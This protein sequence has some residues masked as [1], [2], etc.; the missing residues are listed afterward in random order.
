MKAICQMNYKKEEAISFFSNGHFLGCPANFDD[1][2]IDRRLNL[3]RKF[4]DFLNK[5]YNLVEIGCGN[6]AS[7]FKI[8]KEIKTALGLDI[9]NE[10]FPEIYKYKDENNL[11]NCDFVVYNIEKDNSI[12]EKFDR[13]IC[14]EVIEHLENEDNISVFNDM[15]NANGMIAISVPNKWWIFETHGAKL[16]LLP[17]N[18]VPFFSWLPKT[19]HEKFSNARIYTKNRIIKLLE[20]HNFEILSIEYITALLDVFP[21]GKLK[22]FIVR[23]FFPSDTTIIPFKSTAIFIIAKKK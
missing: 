2:I 13:L 11:N 19:I 9:N 5:E 23:F 1:V 18:R 6:G 12:K 10:H 14:F 22:D 7:I 21:K 16:P 20:K 17:W 4:P 3:L 8:S 15:L